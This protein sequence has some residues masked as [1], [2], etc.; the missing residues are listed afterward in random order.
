[1][2]NSLLTA[3]AGFQLKYPT[4]DVSKMTSEE[5][6][7]ILCMCVPQ[8]GRNGI[9]TKY[10]ASRRAKLVDKSVNKLKLCACPLKN[11]AKAY[12]N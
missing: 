5:I 7:N 9:I 2:S 4:L 3:A 10:V 1:M 8:A 6:N 12:V 11:S